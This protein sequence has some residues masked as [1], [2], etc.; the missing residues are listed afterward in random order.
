MPRTLRSSA[1]TA[2]SLI[3]FQASCRRCTVTTEVKMVTGSCLQLRGGSLDSVVNFNLIKSRFNRKDEEEEEDEEDAISAISRLRKRK[4]PNEV[5]EQPKSEFTPEEELFA[6]KERERVCNLIRAEEQYDETVDTT[7]QDGLSFTEWLARINE[8]E[9]LRRKNRRH[10][11][12]DYGQ[13]YVDGRFGKD[14]IMG[15]VNYVPLPQD[16]RRE[17]L[18]VQP[19]YRLNRHLWNA[20][21][22]GKSAPEGF[23]E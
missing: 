23:K 18:L 3:W 11:E 10:V 8:I 21:S 19:Q 4:R 1:L 9:N 22:K 14:D 7:V 15:W 12:T 6:E 5:Q 20:S 16:V 13:G 2:M 17:D